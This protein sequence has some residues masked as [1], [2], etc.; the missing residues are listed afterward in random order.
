MSEVFF[1][2][3][4]SRLSSKH[5]EEVQRT[6]TARLPITQTRS[7]AGDPDHRRRA[8]RLDE[9]AM[10]QR[11]AAAIVRCCGSWRAAP[12]RKTRLPRKKRSAGRFK[13]LAK[14]NQATVQRCFL[15]PL[16]ICGGRA[17]ATPRR[18]N[19]RAAS[20]TAVRGLQ[21]YGIM[22]QTPQDTCRAVRLF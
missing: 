8:G 15:G 2:F 11:P 13:S 1:S 10:G 6:A 9:R 18:R 3:K 4:P 21:L 14:P 20:A 16:A 17:R 12:T 19:A 5:D 22:A 7:L